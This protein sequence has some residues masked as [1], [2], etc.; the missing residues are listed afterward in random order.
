[1][2]ILRNNYPKFVKAYR[3]YIFVILYHGDCHVFVVIQVSW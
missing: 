3:H 1:M 2:R